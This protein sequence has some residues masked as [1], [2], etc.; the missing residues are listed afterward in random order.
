LK[1]PLFSRYSKGP[2]HAY[3]ANLR[4]QMLDQAFGEYRVELAKGR[5]WLDSGARQAPVVG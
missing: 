5:A 2:E 4:R 3:D 1:N